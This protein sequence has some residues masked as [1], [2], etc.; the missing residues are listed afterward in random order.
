MRFDYGYSEEKKLGKTYDV[1]LMRRTMV[2]VRPYRALVLLSVLLVILITL[3]DLSIPYITKVVIDRHIVPWHQTLKDRNG[4]AHADMEPS[5]LVDLENPAVSEMVEAHP[6]LFKTDGGAAVIPV[7]ELEKTEKPKLKILRNKDLSGLGSITLVFLIIVVFNFILNFIQKVIMEYAGN[8]IMHDLRV[9]L[10]THVQGLPVSFFSKN[11]VARLVTR[12]TNDVQ[13]MHDLFTSVISMVFKDLFLL[14][15]IAA[16]MM[17]MNFRLALV[18][19]VVLPFVL[20]A[21]FGFS[22]RVRDVFRELRVKVAEINTRFSETISG[23]K[24][25]Q[26]F[27]REKENYRVFSRIN[28]ENYTAGMRQINIFA[29]F[30]PVIEMLGVTALAIVVLKGGSHVMDGTVSIGLMA[31]FISY[32]KMF[33]R[34]IRDLAEKYNVL[35]NAMASAERIFML[36]DEKGRSAPEIKQFEPSDSGAFQR[37][38]FEKVWFSYTGDEMVLKDINL[39]IKAGETVAVVGPTGS[40]KTSLI[41]LLVRFYTPEKGKLLYN[42]MDYNTLDVSFL[43]SRIALVMQD[44]FLFSGTIGENIFFSGPE[45]NRKEKDRILRASNCLNLIR[46]MPDGLDTKVLEGGVSLSSGERQMIS[47]ARAFSIDPQLI[48]LD[49][50]TSFVDSQTEMDL[51]KAI[52]N[53]MAGRTCV[54]VAHRLTTARGAHQILVMNHGRIIE[55]GNHLGLMAEKGFYY[56]LNL[57]QEDIVNTA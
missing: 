41:N 6:L 26:A 17:Y 19:F 52:R 43:R 39:D 32:M 9:A 11:P 29:V 47:I 16:L 21:A 45:K 28:H 13:N 46:R 44:P 42:G 36:L 22:R 23:V 31:A 24:V 55:T 30:M 10:Y 56:R 27:S 25:I 50:A 37:I 1:K 49:E 53:L 12:V 35:Q 14:V 3:I 8:R 20:I 51:Q 33:F 4:S 57:L 34:P 7:Q 5:Y 2:L 54:V 15:G 40:G 18:S 48:I 38:S